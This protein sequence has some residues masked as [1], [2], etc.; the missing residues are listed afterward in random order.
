MN[1]KK[2][3]RPPQI[4]SSVEGYLLNRYLAFQTNKE[5]TNGKLAR[6]WSS[7]KI[8][9]RNILSDFKRLF[10]NPISIAPHIA[11][12]LMAFW[13]IF[14]GKHYDAWTMAF[15]GALAHDTSLGSSHSGEPS[16][17]TLTVTVANVADRCALMWSSSLN[18]GTSSTFDGNAATSQAGASAG[19]LVSERYLAPGTGSKNVVFSGGTI[20]VCGVMIYDG[21]DQTTPVPTLNS[22]DGDASPNAIAITMAYSD[23]LRIDALGCQRDDAS[24]PTMSLSVGTSRINSTT[25]Q[26]QFREG[27]RVYENAPGATGSDSK[28]WTS[29]AFQRWYGVLELKAAAA[30]GNNY[31]QTLNETLTLTD[32]VLKRD[33]R[34]LNETITHTDT[35]LKRN[36][37]TLSETISLTDTLTAAKIAVKELTETITH[38]DT[39]LKL[40]GKV[41]TE[42]LN[43]TDTLTRV[44]TAFK[45]FTETISLTDT[46]V[47]TPSRPLSEQLNLTDTLV[48]TPTKNLTETITLTDT[49]IR[50]S[51]KVYTE[52]INLTAT[53]ITL[54]G[55]VLTE[56]ITLTDTLIKKPMRT[57]TETI[58][59]TDTFSYINLKVKE[60][61]ETINLTDTLVSLKVFVRELTETIHLSDAMWFKPIKAVVVW[62]KQVASGSG[63]TKQTPDSSDWTEDEKV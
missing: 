38:T 34:T 2:N 7:Y 23:S 29:N 49:V 52:T 36:G 28:T 56:T 8:Q 4:S 43:L 25:P 61:T 50:I 21:V 41:L 37:R 22:E 58:T 27:L 40:P 30:G 12:S 13:F 14:Q 42:T 10:E 55:R 47:K 59:H 54:P 63:W 32:T 26:N 5:Y 11:Y 18:G 44:W 9:W 46:L 31:S 20:K 24:N 6:E 51:G 17:V 62:T 48:K 1:L 45:T 33:S 15:M 57:F 60:L 3:L 35:V 19:N 16:T 39:L 53:L